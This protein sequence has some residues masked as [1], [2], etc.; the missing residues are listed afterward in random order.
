MFKELGAMMSLLNNKSKIQEEMQKFQAMVP[1]IIA[2]GTAGGGMVTV[3]ANGK[4]EILSCRI[5]EDAMKMNDRE[6][7]EDLTVAATNMALS[8]VR[9]LLAAE[10]QK[11][12]GNMGLPASMLGSLG[13]PGM[14]G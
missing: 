8:K 2:D 5:S 1:T 10:T 4:M 12:A 9:E 14:G 11:M 6:M 7:L 3:K 13:L